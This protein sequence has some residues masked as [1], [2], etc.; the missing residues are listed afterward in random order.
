MTSERLAL[1]QLVL[2]HLRALQWVYQTVHWTAHGPH[3]YGDHRMLQRLYEGKGG[4]PDL[5]EEID[6]LGEKL[7]SYY[8]PTAVYAPTILEKAQFYVAKASETTQ[9][10]FVALS[11]LEHSLQ[12]TIQRAWR[13]NQEAGDRMSL[14]LDD[15]LMSLANE[16]ETA[17]Y[18]LGRRTAS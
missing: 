15:Y 6:S 13:A 11:L 8:G 14:G 7:V 18:L 2:A 12:G 17:I 10:P 16:R 5:A 1:L 3:F 9:D 4:G